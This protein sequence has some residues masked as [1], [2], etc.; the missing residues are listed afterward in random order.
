[1]GKDPGPIHRWRDTAALSRFLQAPGNLDDASR[2]LLSDLPPKIQIDLKGKTG[3]DEELLNYNAHDARL[4]FELW[5]RYGHLW[6]EHEQQ[7]A[8]MTTEWGE[9]GVTL[10]Q[11]LARAY[12]E[13]C[14]SIMEEAQ[15]RLP[16][17]PKCR[18]TSPKGV[19]AECERLGIPV[20]PPKSK[21]EEGFELW[22]SEYADKAPWIAEM[23]RYR[24]ANA[25]KKRC[26]TL[27]NRLRPDGRVRA[28]LYYCGAWTGRWTS[29]GGVNF[30]N[31][32]R[33]PFEGIE[34]RNVIIPADGRM[35]C[36][37]DLGQIEARIINGLA[38]N[39]KMIELLEQGFDPYQGTAL[40]LSMWDGRSELKEEVRQVCK[41]AA[42]SLGYGV[43]GERFAEIAGLEAQAAHDFVW[44]WRD[45]NPE[46]VS[47]WGRM[48]NTMR[49]RVG[50][51]WGLRLPSGRMLRFGK[52]AESPRGELEA[53]VIRGDSPERFWGS[54]IAQAATQALA[55]DVFAH[56]L[57]LLRDH[58]DVRVLFTSHDEVVTEV[59]KSRAEH[60]ER[61]IAKALTTRPTW[62]PNLPLAAKTALLTAYKKA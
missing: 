38:G 13:K 61:D 34:V 31:Q 47:L 48:E 1:L 37:A 20:P 19:K 2:L 6:P 46:I 51:D 32:R 36:V 14:V 9:R 5:K 28:E 17:F 10:D 41:Q 39:Q 43:G 12:V 59:P 29:A 40:Q 49:S 53:V 27:L 45:A 50:N 3:T 7:V 25:L 4:S 35:L 44:R 30:Q 18:P 54:R 42:L 23:G 62:A 57:L 15:S 55:R 58:P 11:T 52:I 33:K 21:D 24:S 16:W 22:F 56:G 60:C 26:E 8:C